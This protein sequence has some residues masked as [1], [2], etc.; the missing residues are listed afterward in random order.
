MTDLRGQLSSDQAHIWI[1]AWDCLP[2]SM[3]SLAVAG[4]IPK[5]TV[6]ATCS[7]MAASGWMELRSHGRRKLRPVALI[8]NRSQERMARLLQEEYEASPN[9]GEFLMKR[10]LDLVVH[11]EDF[12]DNARLD[13]VKNVTGEPLELDRYYR[14]KVAFEFN[15]PQ[16]LGVTEKFKDA[17]A[18]FE[19]QS[20]DTR[21]LWLCD[22]AGIT[23]VRVYVA[24]LHPRMMSRLIPPVLRR[25]Y[26]DEDGPYHKAICNL[27]SSYIMK[28]TEVDVQQILA[29]Q[30]G[31]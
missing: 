4:K 17:K 18:A 11:S 2:D 21:K 31:R 14:E 20:R 16:H 24:D 13:A 30:P 28:A 8:P 7:K 3:R 25:N 5:S 9:K 10:Y 12:I 29:G 19:L 23:L 1:T 22:R 27:C 6:F 26:I 15:G